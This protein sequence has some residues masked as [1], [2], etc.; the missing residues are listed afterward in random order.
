MSEYDAERVAGFFDEYGEQEW[1][2]FESGRTPGPSLDVHVEHLRRFVRPGDRVLDVGAGPGRF[3]IELARLGADVVVADV[4]PGQLELNERHVA[5][6]GCEERVLER[7]VADV[8][9]LGRFEDGSFDTVVCFGGP[10]SYVVEGAPRAAAELVRVVR[11]GGHALV[12]VMSLIGTVTHYASFL[13]DLVRRDGAEP[14]ARIVRT[15]ILPEAP[16]YGH[17]AMK[18][19]R[20]SELVALLSPHG[21]VVALAAAG[22]LPHVPHTEPEVQAFLRETELALASDPGAVAAGQHLLA[23]VRAP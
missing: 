2:R 3:T 8:C 10:L 15:G 9:D 4:S 11:G 12:S 22:L 16:G 6:A 18:L 14:N 13:A 20:P 17:L 23:V 7:V 21:E 5:E 19:Y 1:V